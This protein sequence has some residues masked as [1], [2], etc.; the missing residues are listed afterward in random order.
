MGKILSG[1][2]APPVQTIIN[3]PAPATSVSTSTASTTTDT[4]TENEDSQISTELRTESLLRR[5]R[6]RLGTVTSS[7]RGFLDSVGN[8]AETARKTLLGE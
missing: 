6:G 3:N 7:F 5:S 8:T 2:K 4:S 1:P